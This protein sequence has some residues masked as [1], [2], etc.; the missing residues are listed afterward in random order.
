METN[1]INNQSIIYGC[2]QKIILSTLWIF[3]LLNYLYCDILT[4]MDPVQLKHIISGTAGNL[5]ITQGFLFMAGIIMEIPIAMIMLSRILNFKLNRMLNILAGTIMTLV[6][7]S[8]LFAGT[9][10]TSYYILFSIIEIS[11][12]TFIVG[13]AML[14]KSN[15]EIICN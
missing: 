3:V 5:E 4:L 7:I 13:Y 6:Q 1:V 12:T 9:K 2:Y 15:E 8:S 11:A 10:P 14:W